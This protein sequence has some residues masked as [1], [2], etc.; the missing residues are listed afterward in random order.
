MSFD[1]VKTN[2]EKEGE[3]LLC[4]L[5]DELNEYKDKF[6]SNISVSFFELTEQ[7]KEDLVIAE[8]AALHEQLGRERK[9]MVKLV[10]GIMIMKNILN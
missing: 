1:T 5:R 6:R 10:F 3:S 2:L 7:M 4:Q 9:Q 8:S